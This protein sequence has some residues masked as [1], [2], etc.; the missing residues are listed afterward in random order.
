MHRAA[1]V[2]VQNHADARHSRAD[3]CPRS[4]WDSTTEGASMS[5]ASGLNVVKERASLKSPQASPVFARTRTWCVEPGSRF[6][7]RT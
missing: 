3:A 5:L 7:F 6:F 2:A 1:T 4:G